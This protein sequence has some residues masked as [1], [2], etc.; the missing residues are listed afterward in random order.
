M[1]DY[2]KELLE[3]DPIEQDPIEKHEDFIVEQYLKSKQIDDQDIS[4]V[5][6]DSSLKSKD[7]PF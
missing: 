5:I 1:C 6:D 4:V 3:Q 7:L 2:E